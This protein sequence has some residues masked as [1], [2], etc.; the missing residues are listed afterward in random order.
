MG[1]EQNCSHYNVDQNAL[2]FAHTV[3]HHGAYILVCSTII[4]LAECCYFMVGNRPAATILL[5]ECYYLSAECCCCLNQEQSCSHFIL[6]KGAPSF[7]RRCDRVLSLHPGLQRHYLF[8]RVLLLLW[9]G[10]DLQP[11]YSCQGCSFSLQTL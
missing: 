9:P 8:G 1:R 6:V 10:T 7:C 3:I 4:C 2:L 11:L 5:V